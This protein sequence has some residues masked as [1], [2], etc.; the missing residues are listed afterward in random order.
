MDL[1]Q[2]G[3]L[4]IVEGL[5]EFLPVSSTGHLILTSKLLGLEETEFVKAFTVIIQ[6]AAML[7]VMIEYRSTFIKWIKNI[8]RWDLRSKE[9]QECWSLF[10]GTIPAVILGFLFGSKIKAYLFTTDVVSWSLIVGGVVILAWEHFFKTSHTSDTAF[11][12]PTGSQSFKIGL[13]QCLALIPGTSRSLVTIL[14]SRT[15]GLSKVDATI[16]SFYLAVPVLVGASVYDFY[17]YRDVVFSQNAHENLWP[18]VVGFVASFFVAWLCIRLFLGFV[19]R[20]S[21]RSFG[22]YRILVGVLFLVFF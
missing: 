16:F 14:G 13:F 4:G 8:F 11:E 2:A 3:I 1:L 10:C 6:S 20:F 15:L 5:T 17:K 12:F 19:K 7:A 9:T 21:F 18:L 22:I